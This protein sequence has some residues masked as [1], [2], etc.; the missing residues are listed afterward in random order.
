MLSRGI[1]MGSGDE[2]HVSITFSLG[3]DSLGLRD[4]R[5]VQIAV[6]RFPHFLLIYDLANRNCLLFDYRPRGLMT[7]TRYHLAKSD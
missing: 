5:L 7:G 1:R 6:Q 2:S 4:H 3:I